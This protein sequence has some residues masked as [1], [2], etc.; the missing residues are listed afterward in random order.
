ML[1]GIFNY[2]QQKTPTPDTLGVDLGWIRVYY[3]YT[4]VVAIKICAPVGFKNRLLIS[5]NIWSRTTGKHINWIKEHNDM[6]S[7]VIH[8]VP[9][10]QFESICALV[11]NLIPYPNSD[12]RIEILALMGDPE[13]QEIMNKG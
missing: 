5:Q 9:N 3:S 4:T 12:T 8:T 7:S 13:A 6:G 2:G 1:L 10:D 11:S